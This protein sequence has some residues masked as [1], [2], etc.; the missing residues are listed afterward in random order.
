MGR[1][2][3]KKKGGRLKEREGEAGAQLER[4]RPLRFISLP[5]LGLPQS[6]LSSKGNDQA[7]SQPPTIGG[8]GATKDLGNAGCAHHKTS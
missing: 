7:H 3:A 1:G 6:D 5:D 8:D 2:S 4:H